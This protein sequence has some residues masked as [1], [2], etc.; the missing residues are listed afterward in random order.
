MGLDTFA[1]R[2]RG[3]VALTPEDERA[4]EDARI[5]LC[6]GMYS[7]EGGSFRGKMYASVVLDVADVSLFQEWIPPEVVGEMAAAFDRCDPE[8]VAAEERDVTPA[9]ILELRRFLH[10]CADRGLGLIGWW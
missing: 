5:E 4:F 6:G 7:G 1:S 3:D 2:S 8:R 10:L 9:E